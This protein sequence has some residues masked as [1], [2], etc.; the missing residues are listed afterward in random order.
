MFSNT[1][2]RV[3]SSDWVDKETITQAKQL[4]RKRWMK[5]RCYHKRINKKLLKRFGVNIS[6]PYVLSCGKLFAHP[7]NVEILRSNIGKHNET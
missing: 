7:E 5:G 1:E 6:I 2:I 4:S 3:I